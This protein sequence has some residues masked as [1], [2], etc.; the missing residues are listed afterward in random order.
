M[1]IK[2][3]LQDVIKIEPVVDI[4]GTY[5]THQE[6]RSFACAN[7]ALFHSTLLDPYTQARLQLALL[8]K[9]P[10]STPD[11]LF[12]QARKV[13]FLKNLQFIESLFGGPKNVAKLKTTQMISELSTLSFTIRKGTDMF[14]HLFFVL[15]GKA[16][17]SPLILFQENTNDCFLWKMTL[18]TKKAQD[19][20]SAYGFPRNMTLIENGIPRPY[21]EM[22]VEVFKE[23]THTYFKNIAKPYLDLGPIKE[24]ESYLVD[25]IQLKLSSDHPN[26]LK[27]IL[28]ALS[29]ISLAFIDDAFISKENFF[30]TKVVSIVFA[31]TVGLS[32]VLNYF[33]RM[34]IVKKWERF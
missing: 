18:L 10:K 9:N 26:L 12:T 2:T 34:N 1:A 22:L 25:R 11:I 8:K 23:T 33:H 19:L 6:K 28:G 30:K 21:T 31:S 32:A 7:K 24:T 29:L 27:A 13:I 14:G 15:K 20:K 17:Q 4:L 5:L 16:E 3:T